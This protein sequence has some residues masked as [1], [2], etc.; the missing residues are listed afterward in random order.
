MDLHVSCCTV[1]FFSVSGTREGSREL[2]WV[3]TATPGAYLD[4][5]R[6]NVCL[7]VQREFRS[8]DKVESSTVLL[9]TPCIRIRL[10]SQDDA[11][12]WE[13]IHGD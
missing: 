11:H 2:R 5:G 9:D 8:G 13:R 3:S 1:S 10:A 12:R 4:L 7:V 6:L